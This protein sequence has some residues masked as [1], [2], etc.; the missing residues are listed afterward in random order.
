MSTVIVRGR[1]TGFAQDI[2]SESDFLRPSLAQR[3]YDVMRIS[4]RNKLA[5]GLGNIP[6][7]DG[8][9]HPWNEACHTNSQA[10]KWVETI[11]ATAEIF[12]E[13]LNNLT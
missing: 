12:F 4:S 10:D 7:Q 3:R 1:D 11:V 5:R 2:D 13:M 8:S 9:A 6:S